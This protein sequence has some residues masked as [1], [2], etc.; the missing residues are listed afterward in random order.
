[1]RNLRAYI[2]D[3][4][5]FFE[6]VLKAKR[7]SKKDKTY[8]ER[9]EAHQPTLKQLYKKYDEA[10][11]ND[12]LVSLKQHGFGIDDVSDLLKLYSYKSAIMQKL[13]IAVTTV[14]GVR[15]FNTCQNCTIGEV[16]SFDHFLS[17]NDFSE[18]AVHP[19]NLFPSCSKCNSHKGEI[20]KVNGNIPF[21]NLYLDELPKEPYLFVELTLDKN[22][23]IGTRFYL[24]NRNGIDPAFFER[25]ESHYARLHLCQRFSENADDVISSLTF[26]LE[27]NNKKLSQDLTKEVMLDVCASEKDFYG[28]NYWQTILKETILNDKVVLHFLFSN[29]A[30]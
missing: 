27:S 12:T 4:F 6:K 16:S 1:M 18:F 7:N 25:I 23:T 5:D 20:W 29:V 17:K 24:E 15:A 14:D 21:L 22:N 11:I 2:E 13:K 9:I 26:T 19:K 8:K 10:F 28:Y 30:R 3:S